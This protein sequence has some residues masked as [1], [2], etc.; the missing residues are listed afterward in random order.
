MSL[1]D[2]LSSVRK[3][4]SLDK[5]VSKFMYRMG[6]LNINRYKMQQVFEQ[7]DKNNSGYLCKQ[8]FKD[9]IESLNNELHIEDADEIFDNMD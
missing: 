6:P 7:F 4:R 1:N 9:L 5:A 3:I 8:Q 2:S